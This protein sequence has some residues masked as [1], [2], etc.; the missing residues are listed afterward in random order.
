MYNQWDRALAEGV[1]IERV[2]HLLR[3][4]HRTAASALQN[5]AQKE[6]NGAAHRAHVKH[7]EALPRLHPL[8]EAQ[9]AAEAADNTVRQEE[10][11]CRLRDRVV[12][13]VRYEALTSGR[14]ISE[15]PPT[16]AIRLLEFL[17]LPAARLHTRYVKGG[18]PEIG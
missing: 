16:E 14:S 9:V 17:G 10:F 8:D 1:E 4:P 2:I 6:L 3:D 12:L 7:G 13:E 18:P 15:L 11:R 5:R